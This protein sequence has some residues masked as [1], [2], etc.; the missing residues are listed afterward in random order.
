MK[1]LYHYAYY[2]RQGTRL[3]RSTPN[4]PRGLPT[5][6]ECLR[7]LTAVSH[8]PKCTDAWFPVELL[9]VILRS[10]ASD[11]QYTHGLYEEFSPVFDEARLFAVILR[12]R[13][14]PKPRRGE[15]E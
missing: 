15:I 3:V 13:P 9:P 7:H 12:F 10:Y 1:H 5:K 6:K 2:Y 11:G 8:K 4:V 14:A